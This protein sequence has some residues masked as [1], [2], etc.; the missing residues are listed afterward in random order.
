MPEQ[1]GS[2]LNPSAMPLVDA[3]RVLSR[4]GGQPVTLEMLQ[5]DVAADAGQW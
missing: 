5:A 4:A 3:A 2:G 1:N